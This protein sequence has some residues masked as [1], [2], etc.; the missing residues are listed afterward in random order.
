MTGRLRGDRGQVAGIETVP[1]ALLVIT[2]GVLLVARS[3]AVIDAG[4]TAST[5]ARE[6]AATYVGA[7][8]PVDGGRAA[9]DAA[10]TVVDHGGRRTDEVTV[11][12]LDDP[13]RRCQPVTA[14]VTVRVPGLSLPWLGLRGPQRATAT[15]TRLI[16]PFRDHLPGVAPCPLP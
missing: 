15:H 16:D 1:F 5:A 13:W 14:R 11:T 9:R 6:A 10:V 3:W 2:V 7:P 8:N 12:G 4:L